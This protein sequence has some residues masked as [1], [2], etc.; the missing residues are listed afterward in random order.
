MFILLSENPETLL[1]TVR[2]RCTHLQMQALPEEILRPALQNAY[3]DAAASDLEAAL[4]RSGGFLGQA[5]TFLEEGA[6]LS[7]QTE[8]FVQG[9]AYREPLQ[10]LRVLTPMEKWKRDQLIPTLSQWLLLLQ[11]ALSCR[12]GA[13]AA[14]DAARTLAQ[15]R[16]PKELLESIRH[17]QKAIEYAQ[18]N[19]SPAAVCGWLKW[20][21]R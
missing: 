17:L 13:P 2:S 8:G 5:L 10:L 18:S 19:V 3:P 20:V 1:P 9:F 7:E 4:W 15:Q 16:S 14:T 12:S 21:L 11:Q 6:R